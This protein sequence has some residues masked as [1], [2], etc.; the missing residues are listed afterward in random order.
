MKRKIITLLLTTLFVSSA[1]L[2][3]DSAARKQLQQRSID[4]G[5]GT[6]Q[7]PLLQVNAGPGRQAALNAVKARFARGSEKITLA[8]R[9]RTE[10]KNKSIMYRGP[11][12]AL[13]VA[14]DGRKV[15][16]RNFAYLDGTSN[17]RVPVAQRPAQAELESKGRRFV[18]EQ[19]K[20]LVRLGPG[21]ELVPLFTEYQI[22][23]GGSTAADAR[24]QAETV[25]AAHVVFS[26]TINGVHVIGPGSKVVVIFGADGTIAGFEYDWPDYQRSRKVQK[27]VP[28]AEV[29][30]RARKLA[31]EDVARRDARVEKI[32]CGYLDRGTDRRD[33]TASL[34]LACAIYTVSRS[35]VDQAAHQRD[36][37][38]GH[39]T[40]A[41]ITVVPAGET[42]EP[43]PKW[44]L[45]QKHLGRPFIGAEPPKDGPRR[46][47]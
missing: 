3:G 43:D 28:I 4:T 39:L 34:Q 5:V 12:W 18:A 25:G 17:E 23:G 27:S 44:P 1:V 35:I 42:V 37:G 13:E 47:Q 7:A 10:A 41:K 6:A 14:G 19:L 11:G 29:R 24:R 31:P 45:A 38:S 22:A 32:E 36:S 20:D 15:R 9:T 46:A 2:A 26:R 33:A 8:G 40:I 30:E 16:Y 21:E